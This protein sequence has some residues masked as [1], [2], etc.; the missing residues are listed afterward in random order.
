MLVLKRRLGESILIKTAGIEFEV[1]VSDISEGKVKLAI[2]APMEVQILRKEVV[3]EARLENTMSAQ[4]KKINRQA[5]K[6]LKI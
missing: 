2:D 4:N 5:L 3:D 6:D 1:K